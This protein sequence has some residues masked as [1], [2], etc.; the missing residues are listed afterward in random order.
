LFGKNV[1]R[2][3]TDFD[4]LAR[5]DFPDTEIPGL[6]RHTGMEAAGTGKVGAD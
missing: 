2:R 4:H 3:L 5:N 6:R 1:F